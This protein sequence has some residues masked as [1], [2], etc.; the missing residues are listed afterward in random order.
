MNRKHS[1]YDRQ[2]LS[3]IPAG[4]EARRRY[5]RPA[6]MP[7]GV[8]DIVGGGRKGLGSNRGRRPAKKAARET[9]TGGGRRKTKKIIRISFGLVT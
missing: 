1:D 2:M 6:K 4:Q 3:N 8:E 9:D 7:A 5:S